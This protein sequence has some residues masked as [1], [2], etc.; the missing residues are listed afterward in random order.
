MFPPVHQTADVCTHL[1]IGNSFDGATGAQIHPTGPLNLHGSF[2]E[3]FFEIFPGLE[4]VFY[5]LEYCAAGAIG[6]F[7]SPKLREELIV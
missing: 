2:F 1:M 4:V 6:G 5:Q 3:R 7:R